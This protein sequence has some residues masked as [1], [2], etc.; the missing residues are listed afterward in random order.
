MQYCEH[1]HQLFHRQPSLLCVGFSSG[2]KHSWVQ[3]D[4]PEWVF[5]TNRENRVWI[6]DDATTSDPSAERVDS[7]FLR[8][9][10]FP[11]RS[12]GPGDHQAFVTAEWD[13]GDCIYHRVGVLL[14]VITSYPGE[15]A[16][17]ILPAEFR[18]DGFDY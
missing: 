17:H 8:L 10:G 3:T 1:C 14:V 12:R 7:A 16:I 15:N 9:F 2:G 5:A 13:G 4:Q 18:R 6:E 11:W